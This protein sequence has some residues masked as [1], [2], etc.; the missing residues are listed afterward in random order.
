M[1]P[2]RLLSVEDDPDLQRLLALMLADEDFEVH[3][4]FTGPD[5]LAKAVALTPDVIL[6]DLM[7]PG[8]GGQELIRRLKAYPGTRDIPIVVVTAYYDSAGLTEAEIRRLGISEYVRKPVHHR[9]LLQ[10]LRRAAGTAAGP[11]A[12]PVTP[13]GRRGAEA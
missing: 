8:Y 2:I 6:C 9:E 5:G 11:A 10:L 13:S 7:L 12:V 4:A 3:L 1:A